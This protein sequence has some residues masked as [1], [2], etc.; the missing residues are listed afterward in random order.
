M[1][2]C[3]RETDQMMRPQ[4]RKEKQKETESEAR[5]RNRER[6]WQRGRGICWKEFIPAV[7]RKTSGKER[8]TKMEMHYVEMW[9][10]EAPRP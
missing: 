4:K 2:V 7:Y 8:M 10:P 5:D 6:E 3:V 9:I 1:Y